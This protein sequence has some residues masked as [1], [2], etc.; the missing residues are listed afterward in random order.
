MSIGWGSY[1]TPPVKTNIATTLAEGT[2]P[3]FPEN[4]KVIDQD[5]KLS[6]SWRRWFTRQSSRLSNRGAYKPTDY[7]YNGMGAGVVTGNPVFQWWKQGNIV[8][9]Y[10]DIQF[11]TVTAA[12]GNFIMRPLPF[13]P[14]INILNNGGYPR[15]TFVLACMALTPGGWV[16]LP[17]F[18][19]ND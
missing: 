5:Q 16:S 4:E 11:T 7:V 13:D 3:P 10:L 14:T 15:P 6:P 9:V 1:S 2:L 12:L 8:Q 18:C 19:L 17:C